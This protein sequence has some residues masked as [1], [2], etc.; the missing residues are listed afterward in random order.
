[1]DGVGFV[2]WFGMARV[3]VSCVRRRRIR[4]DMGAFLFG[5]VV[6]SGGRACR[7]SLVGV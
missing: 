6:K 2:R 5:L 1:M 7:R 3:R 4:R